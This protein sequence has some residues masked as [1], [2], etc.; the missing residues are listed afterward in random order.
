MSVSGKILTFKRKPLD[1]EVTA[2]GQ[3]QQTMIWNSVLR[4]D[5]VKLN[6]QYLALRLVCTVH[7]FVIRTPDQIREILMQACKNKFESRSYNII[8]CLRLNGSDSFSNLKT[9]SSLQSTSES[10]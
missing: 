3:G 2:G 8:S 4:A 5:I 7:L 9:R 10:D 6:S 1:P